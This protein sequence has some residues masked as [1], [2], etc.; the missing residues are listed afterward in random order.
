MLNPSRLPKPARVGYVDESSFAGVAEEP[1]LAHASDENVGKTVVVV[2]ANRDAHAIHFDIESG[3]R[4][5]VG[6][7]S[8]A[9]VVVEAQR[10]AA[11]LVARPVRAIDQQN[12]LPAV[13]IVI[14]E[15]AAGA[16]SFGQEFSAEGAAVVLEMNARLSGDIGETKA[17]RSR[18]EPA[19]TERAAEAAAS[20][21]RFPPFPS[22]KDLRFTERSPAR[23]EWRRPP[24]PQFCE[25]PART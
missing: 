24:A 23:R 18:R 5:H 1:V 19:P 3:A 25:C 6:E 7:S 2:I 17:G 22:R 12:V 14:E 21:M 13:A 9:V 10:G 20:K 8:V 15:G 16:Q 11:L 4:R